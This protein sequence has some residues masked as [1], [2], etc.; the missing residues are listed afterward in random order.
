MILVKKDILEGEREREV[1]LFATKRGMVMVGCFCVFVWVIL[2]I[3]H[4][5][6]HISYKRNKQ[7]EEQILPTTTN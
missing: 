3:S 7:G 2:A 4:F 1:S 5:I 6:C